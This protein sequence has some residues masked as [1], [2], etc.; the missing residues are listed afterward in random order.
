MRINVKN[1]DEKIKFGS[2]KIHKK[3]KGDVN[4]AHIG[5]NS[6]MCVKN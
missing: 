1:F 6:W 3:N 4:Y 2:W 5:R